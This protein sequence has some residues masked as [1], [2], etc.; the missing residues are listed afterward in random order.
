MKFKFKKITKK[1]VLI[2]ITSILAVILL[3]IGGFYMYVRHQ[4]YSATKNLPKTEVVV[5][6]TNDKP[7]A[8]NPEDKFQEQS[9]IT[10]ILLIGTDARVLS[11]EAR[12]D[13]MVIMTIDDN[14]KNIKLTS[15][16][17]DTYVDIK[18][19]SPQKINAAL[20]LGGPEL[21]MD[22][23]QRNFHIKL[24]KY[25]L[26]NFQGFEGLVDSIGGLDINV[27]K[28]EIDEINKFIGET[29][30]VKSPPLT[31]DGLQHL[32]G[33][34][35]LSYSRIRHVGNGVY[36]RDERQRTVLTLIADKLKDT[37]FFQY[38]NVLS[39]LLPCFK[40][41]IEPATLLNYAYTA[42]KFKP[43]TIN[44]LQMPVTE[45]SW[46]G[47]YKGSWVFLMDKEQNQQILNDF[48]FKNKMYDKKDN[49]M[50]SYKEKI[51][52]YLSQ[53]KNALPSN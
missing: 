47:T 31:H 43:M 8:D 40:T 39:K 50:N 48:I 27:K 3:S 49:D 24:D 41:N 45:L 9:G 30:K 35:A 36:E 18:G 11:E 6:N 34:Q 15:L 42:S 1:K 44:Q 5:A 13:S 16:M 33:Q 4:I 20:Q 12:S 51:D 26:V 17:R 23:I 10:N 2:A 52:G 29:D 46:G 22:T 7:K 21:L 28:I 37:S 32:D 14:N 19:H 38:P 53:D 25:L